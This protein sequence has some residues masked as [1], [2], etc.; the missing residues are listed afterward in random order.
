MGTIKKLLKKNMVRGLKDVAFERIR[1][2]VYVKPTSF[3]YTSY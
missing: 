1:F 2:I 3:K